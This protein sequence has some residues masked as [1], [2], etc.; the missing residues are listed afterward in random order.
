MKTML[1][2]SLRM[3]RLRTGRASE[4]SPRPAVKRA[5]TRGQEQR[6]AFRIPRRSLAAQYLFQLGAKLRRDVLAVERVG[7]IGG[8]ESDLGAAVEAFSFKLETVELLLLREP[9]H[10]VG[11]LD[12]IARAARLIGEDVENLRLQD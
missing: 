3:S 2:M 7:D 12:L 4:V 5:K 8:Q 10:G 11:E 1:R 6:L 9:D